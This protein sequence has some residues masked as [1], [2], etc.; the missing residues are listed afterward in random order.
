M[1]IAD[2]PIVVPVSELHKLDKTRA[3]FWATSDEITA[4]RRAVEHERESIRLARQRI[5]E[6]IREHARIGEDLQKRA[7]AERAALDARE[8]A[9]RKRAVALDLQLRKAL[10]GE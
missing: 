5:D 7:V 10:A 8:V 2:A 3:K 4:Q 6:A 9:L 1:S